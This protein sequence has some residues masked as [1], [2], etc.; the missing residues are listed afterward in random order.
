MDKSLNN[1]I[2]LTRIQKL[3]GQRM[4]AS[5]LSKPC[6][7]L[8]TTA[9]VTMLVELR[10]RLRKMLGVKIT[11][12]TFYV[13]VLAMAAEKYPLVLGRF[14]GENI[15]I[16]DTVNVGFAVMASHGLIVPVIKDAD[17][18][19]LVQIAEEEKLLT[20]GARSNS[21]KLEQIEGETIALSNLGAYDVDSFFGIV[22]MPA[23]VILSVGNVLHRIVPHEGRP[24]DAGL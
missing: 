24:S 11:T 22:P 2:P 13:R 9:D 21:L 20:D 12:N 10:P 14:D 8:E 19:S 16:A 7:Y 23:S 15:T 3:I 6:F 18:K 17:K 4:L 5:K 1:H